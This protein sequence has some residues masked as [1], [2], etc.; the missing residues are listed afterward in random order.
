MLNLPTLRTQKPT[1]TM[2]S[3]EG[4]LTEFLSNAGR[5][6]RHT[7]PDGNSLFHSLSICLYNHEEE[8]LAVRKILVQF[9]ELNK[10][11]FANYLTDADATDI[12][13]HVQGRSQGGAKGALA[14]PFF[15]VGLRPSI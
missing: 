9:E 1:L 12:N 14:P 2:C 11:Q 7:L 8:H 10:D 3:S 15:Q 4:N 13:D 5:K 6:V